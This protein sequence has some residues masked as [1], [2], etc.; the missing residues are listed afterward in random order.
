[1][2]E[3]YLTEERIMLN[4]EVA[5]WRELV[6]KVGKLMLDAGD[7]EPTY[8]KA[9]KNIIEEM[10]PYAVIAPG[11]VLLHARPESGVKR[12]SFV[13]A[14]LKEGINFGSKNDPVKL[15]IGLGALDHEGHIELLR[16]L[17]IF[18]QNKEKL[19]KIYEAKNKKEFIQI[20]K[21]I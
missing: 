6:D 7:I 11:A 5:N 2:I 3:K 16:D 12:I 14:T 1:M 8:I 21:N 19:F 10:G 15:A 13:M 20:I 4:L 18:L 9:M 17:S